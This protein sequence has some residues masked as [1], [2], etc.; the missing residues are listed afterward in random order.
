MGCEGNRGGR[1]NIRVHIERLIL[2]GLNVG[3]GDAPRVQA[4]VE[5][6]LAR[7]VTTDGL[8]PALLS[9][10]ALAEVTA[11]NVTLPRGRNAT[12]LGEQIAQSVYQ[13]IGPAGGK[14]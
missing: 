5:T 12:V 10:A 7:M 4:A 3:A 8:A 14:R 13:G 11:G 1:M 2:D 9:G 6:E